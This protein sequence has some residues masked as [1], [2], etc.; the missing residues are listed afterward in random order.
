MNIPLALAAVL[1]LNCTV[2]H[3]VKDAAVMTVKAT[4]ATPTLHTARQALASWR[5]N[6]VGKQ[7][8]NKR[9]SCRPCYP[10]PHRAQVIE[11]LATAYDAIAAELN[12]RGA[13]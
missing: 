6:L 7:R 5:D 13:L 1:A 12:R 2:P 3:Y 11:A 9:H 10:T 8:K 4:D